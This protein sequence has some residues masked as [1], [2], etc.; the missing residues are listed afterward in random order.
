MKAWDFFILNKSLTLHLKKITV[1][2]SQEQLEFCK[3]CKKRTF[4]SSI[5]I[6]CSITNAKPNFTSSCKDYIIDSR[7]VEKE[8]SRQSSNSRDYLVDINEDSK[9][10]PSWKIAL[11]IILFIIAI[12]RLIAT[13]SK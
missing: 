3:K 12:I 6:V 4:N 1:L 10:T 8:L 7:H 13:F 9:P 11:S 5:G 2:T